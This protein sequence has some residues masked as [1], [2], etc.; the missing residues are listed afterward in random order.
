MEVDV[1]DLV[2]MKYK[3][4]GRGDGGYDCYGL[5]LEVEKRFGNVLPDFEYEDTEGKIDEESVELLKNG[6][7]RKIGDFIP[8][9]IILLQNIQG[10]KTHIGVYL[11]DGMF[12][13]SHIKKNVCIDTVYSHRHCI[14]GVYLWQQK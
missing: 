12:I 10:M 9:A 13:H 4:H 11:G 6:N 1:S 5:T 2:G 8:G 14:S 3:P 7:A